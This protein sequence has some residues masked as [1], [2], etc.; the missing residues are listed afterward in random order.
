MN[1]HADVHFVNFDTA[2]LARLLAVRFPIEP[3]AVAGFGHEVDVVE[4]RFLHPVYIMHLTT[5]M[6]WLQDRLPMGVRVAW[7]APR[8]SDF[9]EDR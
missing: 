9:V 8:V 6:R 2:F 3:Y 5:M 1:D 4:V 7:Q